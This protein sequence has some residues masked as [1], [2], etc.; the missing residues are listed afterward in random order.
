MMLLLDI[1]AKL[2]GVY[3]KFDVIIKILLKL[4]LVAVVLTKIK[5]TVGFNDG[6]SKGSI[7]FLLSLVSAFLPSSLMTLVIIAYLVLQVLSA[8]T[9][10]ALMVLLIC[11]ILYCFFLRFTPKQSAVVVAMPVLRSI[12]FPYVLPLGLGLFSNLMSIIPVCC[13]VFGY[14]LVSFIKSNT[15][16]L[17]QVVTS[18][19][20]EPFVMYIDVITKL[21]KYP[22]MYVIM[23]IYAAVI[24]VVYFVRRLNMDYSFEISIG[25]GSGVMLLGYIIGSLK[26]DLGVSLVSVI[27]CTLISAAL[28]FVF[29][30]FYRVLNYAATEHVQFED[31]DYYYYVKAVPKVN[32]GVPKKAVKKIVP[33][34]LEN[35]EDFEDEALEAMDDLLWTDGAKRPRNAEPAEAAERKMPQYTRTSRP[36]DEKPVTSKAPAQTVKPVAP[37]AP[38]QTVKPAAPKTPA[39]T[40]KPVAPKAPTQAAKEISDTLFE[41]EDED[42]L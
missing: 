28:V 11:I 34:G 4:I 5:N 27:L 6:I 10:M 37:K 22:P 13:G 40:V 19:A 23:F 25:V 42:Y 39:Q 15:L 33:R 1:R 21:I 12:G 16:A 38:A 9:L 24:I 17:E 20:A 41:E 8:S 3:Q 30:F 2:I 36:T 32:T 18:E 29:M 31:D 7:I 26:Y 14:Y 35:D